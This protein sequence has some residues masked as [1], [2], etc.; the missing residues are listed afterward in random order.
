MMNLAKNVFRAA[1]ADSDVLFLGETGTGKTLVADVFH[2]VSQ[3]AEK[4]FIRIDCNNIATNLFETEIFG[5]VKGAF[6]GA[7]PDKPGRIVEADGGILFLDEIGDLP[8]EQQ[9]KLLTF[10]E[11]K[12]FSPVGSI[13]T[14][15][16]DVLILMATNKPLYEKVKAGEFRKDL[17]YRLHN[18]VIQNPPLKD[19]PEDIPDLVGQFIKVF[20]LQYGKAVTAVSAEVMARLQSLPWDGNVRQLISCIE[21]GVKNCLDHLII[22][23]D[24]MPFLRREGFSRPQSKQ[25]EVQPQDWDVDYKTFK[26][27]ILHQLERDYLKRKLDQHLWSVTRTAKAIGLPQHQYLNQLMRRFDLKREKGNDASEE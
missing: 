3:R 8:P 17:Y 7:G 27:K 11:N 4:P 25:P 10:L 16:L 2:Q 6:T 19:H 14:Y 9:G 12:T 13:D 26:E 24:I 5:Y 23:Q 18:T 22:L 21:E 1:Q 20:N 15:K